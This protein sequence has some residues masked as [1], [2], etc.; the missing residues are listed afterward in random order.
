MDLNDDS[1]I[2]ILSG[3][4]SRMEGGMAGLFQVFW[5]ADDGTFDKPQAVT[6]TDGQPLILPGDDDDAV[7]DRICTRPTAVDLNG[8]G[9]LDIVSGNFRGT[10]FLIEG[11][12][13]GKFSPDA[14]QLM[15]TNGK[16]LAVSAHSD[17]FF[18]D[19]DRDGDLDL[20][21]GS[22][23][24]VHL[25]VNSGSKTEP[26]FD[27]PT[28]ILKGAGHGTG[29]LV[30]GADHYT[31]PASSLRVWV[32][33]MNGD[34]LFDILM[35]DSTVLRYPAEG[36]DEETCRARYAEWE[37][38]SKALREAQQRF[39]YENMSEEEQ[40]EFDALNEQF[41]KHYQK[42][43]EFLREDMTGSVWVAYQ[44]KPAGS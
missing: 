35:G 33:D 26:A 17:P 21:S 32:E 14:V 25:C 15:A 11:S 41:G 8:D 16:P 5:G 36:V 31:K 22:T 40:E 6:G 39:D 27:P 19:W 12:G 20:V 28:D 10:F 42:R 9:H 38:E 34:G 7:I 43:S 13:A 29:D 18:V 1:N 24:G 3:S 23:A 4:Y 37:A 30:L 44:E 2:D